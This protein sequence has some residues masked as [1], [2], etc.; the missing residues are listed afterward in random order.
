[1]GRD[2]GESRSRIQ[3]TQLSE[4]RGGRTEGITPASSSGSGPWATASL[5]E[6][7]RSQPRRPRAHIR[8][9]LRPPL[10][11]ASRNPDPRPALQAQ[12]GPRGRSQT[13]SPGLRSGLQAW[14]AVIATGT[15]RRGLGRRGAG[16][17]ERPALP[18]SPRRPGSGHGGAIREPGPAAHRPGDP[19]LWEGQLG[20]QGH[21]S[22]WT[23]RLG[24][25]DQQ[26]KD[27]PGCPGPAPLPAAVRPA[28][29]PFNGEC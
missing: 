12:L 15:S 3:E 7:P 1:M 21:A 16:K 11:A 4:A 27:L 25:P 9:P 6:Q 5:P 20:F 13:L 22:R 19:P 26:S 2:C 17:L 18:G 10:G 8:R 14:P 23:P 24:V 29:P 28:P